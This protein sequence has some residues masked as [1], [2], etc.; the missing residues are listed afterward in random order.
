MENG[1]VRCGCL[2]DANDLIEALERRM[3]DLEQTCLQG[4]G[5]VGAAEVMTTTRT[6]LGVRGG[7]GYPNR[8][9]RLTDSYDRCISGRRSRYDV[10]GRQEPH[11][12]G[13]GKGP[14]TRP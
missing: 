13:L 1:F 6:D 9:R 5:A 4:T 2:V 8:G 12:T 7:Q 3:A 11:R 10:D 14:F